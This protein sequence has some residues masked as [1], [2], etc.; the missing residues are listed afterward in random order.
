[1][2]GRNDDPLRLDLHHVLPSKLV[3][4]RLSKAELLQQTSLS[5]REGDD[6]A[7]RLGL[8]CRTAPSGAHVH[9]VAESFAVNREFHLALVAA[10]GNPHLDQFAGMLW[11]TRIGVPIFAGQ[12]ADHPE[13]V[14]AW[15]DQ[16]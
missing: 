1:M 5:I 9:D 3:D 14:R 6:A 16:H 2:L 8:D 10:A 7:L 4:A 11:L 13:D 12:A 15:A